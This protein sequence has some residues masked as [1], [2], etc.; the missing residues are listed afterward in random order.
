MSDLVAGFHA[1][2]HTDV[3][4]DRRHSA[5]PRSSESKLIT[6]TERVTLGL[7]AR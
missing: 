6:D 2:A 7:G 3:S 4:P 1:T 5:F